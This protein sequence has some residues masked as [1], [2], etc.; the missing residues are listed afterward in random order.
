M[1]ARAQQEPAPHQLTDM[2][3]EVGGAGIVDRYDDGAAQGATE[4]RRHPLRRVWRPQQN[5]L[6]LAY[7][8]VLEFASKLVCGPGHLPV[9]PAD[10]PVPATLNVG[11]LIA[12][13]HKVF[14]VS[15]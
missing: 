12:L 10:D 13:L 9:A 5:A 6:A 1:L 15:H 14:E 8:S 2:L 7:S 11:T 3:H 4:E